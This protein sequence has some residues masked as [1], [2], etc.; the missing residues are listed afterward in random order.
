VL[1]VCAALVLWSWGKNFLR[2][3]PAQAGFVA[4][5]PPGAVLTARFSIA[6]RPLAIIALLIL[7]CIWPQGASQRFIYFQF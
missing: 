1:A 4:A 3:Q 6:I 5:R 7:V 2:S